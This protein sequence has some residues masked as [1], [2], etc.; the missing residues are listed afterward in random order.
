MR[1]KYIINSANIAAL[2]N[3]M[4]VII[5][6]FFLIKCAMQRFPS[7]GPADKTPPEI[8]SVYP[9]SDS[10]HIGIYLDKIKIVF[11]E[12]MNEGTLPNS[13]FISPLLK[14]D[15]KWSGSKEL[16]VTITDTLKKDQT[17]VIT[18]GSAAQDEHNNKLKQSFQSAFSTGSKIDRGSI[19]GR[20]Y[21]LKRNESVNIFAY[22]LT[23]TSYIDIQ[24]R[25]PDYIS[26]SGTK[27]EYKFSF[28]KAGLYR[29]FAVQ[30]QNNNLIIDQNF[31]MFGVPYRD[32]FIDSSQIH[33]SGLGF[34]LSKSDTTRP[35]V[36]GAKSLNEH[37]IRV[38]LNK[39]VNTP[40]I[41]QITIVDSLKNKSLPLLGVSRSREENFFLELYTETLDRESFYKVTI[42]SL[43][44]SIGNETN[45]PQTTRSFPGSLKK[46]TVS[47]KLLKFAPLDSAKGVYPKSAIHFEFSRPMDLVS[48]SNAFIL[49]MK[50]G[51]KTEGTWRS[52]NL[53]QADFVP[54]NQLTADSFYVARLSLNKIR[55]IWG[56]FAGDSIIEHS[57]KTI[58]LRELGEISGRVY[59]N[60]PVSP[61][62]IK[63]KSL[64]KRNNFYIL[65][66]DSAGKFYKPLLP[67]GK[68]LIDAFLDIDKNGAYS[69]G[70]LDPFS[71]A[72]PFVFL[73]DTISVRNRWETSD[74]K[75]EIP[76]GQGAHE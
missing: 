13:L 26:Q 8:M 71:Y 49:E 4:L 47:L 23:D 70:T 36:I 14:Y 51:K 15:L 57:F 38:R 59:L 63:F 12:R 20:V 21:G 7:G 33:F 74:V 61:I 6:S 54:V 48:I 44:D 40:D 66:I 73:N 11:S 17:Y 16:T 69:Y 58:A 30:D 45:I 60:Q 41:E 25:K 18:I 65:K 43:K 68:Y 19:S 29:I 76:F 42:H 50:N 24:N 27:G 31:E 62:F 53:Y 52:K 56:T 46:D 22:T 67:G 39:A 28:L 75:I 1:L 37:I 2:F 5:I 35:L 32:V 9:R 10:T 34:Q 3:I 55:D 64:N 72:E